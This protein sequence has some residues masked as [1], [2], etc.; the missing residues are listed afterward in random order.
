MKIYLYT[1]EMDFEDG[2][3]II[4][5]EAQNKMFA[6]CDAEIIVNK[7]HDILKNKKDDFY[8]TRE[9]DTWNSFPIW[10]V[11]NGEIISFNYN[12]YEYF[13]DTDRR[14]ILG[15][16][17]GHLYNI[18]SELKIMR[19]TLKYIMDTL[20]ITY[21]NDFERFNKKVEKLIAKNPK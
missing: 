7:D 6:T 20:Q 8:R 4:I 9:S 19:K 18:P 10:E 11:V 16:K 1:K 2:N 5:L 14:K 15:K 21:P 13:Q 17:V 12:N 3:H